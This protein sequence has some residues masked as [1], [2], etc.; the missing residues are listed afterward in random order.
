MTTY[1]ILMTSSVLAVSLRLFTWQSCL[2]GFFLSSLALETAHFLISRPMAAAMGGGTALPTLNK[3]T[4]IIDISSKNTSM[5]RQSEVMKPYTAL[6][7]GITPKLRYN[8]GRGSKGMHHKGIQLFFYKY[9][10]MNHKGN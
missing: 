5:G 2:L 8:L 9:H 3:Q 10:V 7:P 1:S 6:Q 4:Q